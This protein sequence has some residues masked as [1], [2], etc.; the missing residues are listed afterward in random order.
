MDERGFDGY[1]II[2]DIKRILK[3]CLWDSNLDEEKLKKI[4]LEND[5]REMY[6]LFSKI[7]YNSRDKLQALGIFS[8][9]QLQRYFGKFQ[10]TYNEKYINKHILVLKS[11]LL[12]ESHDIKGLEWKKR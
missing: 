10:A 7:I 11:L 5:D 4:L 9:D 2:A 8:E 6:K 1:G 3:E 12:G